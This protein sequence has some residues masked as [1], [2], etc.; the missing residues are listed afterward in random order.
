MLW[1]DLKTGVA[2]LSLSH[3]VFP[4]S[5]YIVQLCSTSA[6]QPWIDCFCLFL[7]HDMKESSAALIIECIYLIF[8]AG[9]CLHSF[10]LYSALPRGK[11]HFRSPETAICFQFSIKLT[12]TLWISMPIS[13]AFSWTGE[14]IFDLIQIRYHAIGRNWLAHISCLYRV[15]ITCIFCRKS[16]NYIHFLIYMLNLYSLVRFEA[17]KLDIWL[18]KVDFTASELTTTHVLTFPTSQ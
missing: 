11:L 4:M 8:D 7:S 2:P 10:N 3:I 5:I 15:W 1:K 9:A 16:M 14:A 18:E 6:V 17:V 13:H 12:R